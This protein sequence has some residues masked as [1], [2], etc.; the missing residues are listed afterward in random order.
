MRL[1]TTILLTALLVALIP[2]F[3]LAALYD[4]LVKEL[5]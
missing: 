2:V 1:F 5:A 3:L 4:R